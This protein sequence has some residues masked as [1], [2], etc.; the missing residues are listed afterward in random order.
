MGKR[1]GRL[2]RADEG[3]TQETGDSGRKVLKVSGEQERL[4][5][6]SFV[7]FG[8]EVALHDAG[9]VGVSLAMADEQEMDHVRVSGKRHRGKHYAKKRGSGAG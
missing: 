4:L 9:G 2:L 1:L 5:T 3:R 6:A 7:E 8:G